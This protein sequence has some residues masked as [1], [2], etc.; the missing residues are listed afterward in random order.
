MEKMKN[1][2]AVATVEENGKFY[3]WAVQ[4]TSSDN[5]LKK[6]NL[7]NLVSINVYTT[8]AKAFEIVA[9]WNTGY[10]TENKYLFDETF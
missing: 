4:F 2:W 8:K 9:I 7:E 6:V 3:S 10:K 1:L 5:L